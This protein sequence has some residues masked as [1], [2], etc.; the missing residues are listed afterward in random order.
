L[1]NILYNILLLFNRLYLYQFLIKDFCR[2]RRRRRRRHRRRRRR[3]RYC[4]Y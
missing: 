4:N 3:R 2:R 1:Y